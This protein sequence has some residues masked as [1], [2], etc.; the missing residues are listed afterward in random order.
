MTTTD[1]DKR[2]EEKWTPVQEQVFTE[3][4][5]CHAPNPINGMTVNEWKTEYRP[6][7][8]RILA[9][10]RSEWEVWRKYPD[11]KPDGD[12]HSDQKPY[13]VLREGDGEPSILWWPPD[14]KGYNYWPEVI[15]FIPIPSPPPPE[16]QKGEDRK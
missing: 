3:L 11:E 1:Q 5:V 12:I 14:E 7:I 15:L 8:D 4:A 10:A 16:S 9:G 2:A 13:V 6:L